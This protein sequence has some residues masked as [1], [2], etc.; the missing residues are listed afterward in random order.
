MNFLISV[1]IIIISILIGAFIGFIIPFL[2]AQFDDNPA[3]G[4][5]PMITIPIGTCETFLVNVALPR[6]HRGDRAWERP[7]LPSQPR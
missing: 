5:I 3:W 2:I 4:F 6:Q 1:F 7:L